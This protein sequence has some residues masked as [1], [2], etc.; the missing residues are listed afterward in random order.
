MPHAQYWRPLRSFG[1]RRTLT[2]ASSVAGPTLPPQRHRLSSQGRTQKAY[3]IAA[4]TQTAS[5]RSGPVAWGVSRVLLASRPFAR[6]TLANHGVTSMPLKTSR[7]V[8][9]AWNAHMAPVAGWRQCRCHPA[10]PNQPAQRARSRTHCHCPW[11]HRHRRHCH[12]RQARRRHSFRPWV[13]ILIEYL[14]VH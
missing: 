12:H 9:R 5:A 14:G 6:Y 11:S 3:Q 2:R 4:H 13:A 10:A 1:L 7:P 8:V